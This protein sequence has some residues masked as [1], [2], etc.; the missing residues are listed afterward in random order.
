MIKQFMFLDKE[1]VRCSVYNNRTSKSVN[2]V[3]GLVAEVR[4]DWPSLSMNDLII[5]PY[6]MG[7]EDSQRYQYAI[8]F[9]PHRPV[10]EAIQRRGYDLVD[11][12]PKLVT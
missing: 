5:E 3:A 8:E 11:R 2:Y 9:T 7:N 6:R 10:L 1:N 12:L 4:E